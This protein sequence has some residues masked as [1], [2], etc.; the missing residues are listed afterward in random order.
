MHFDIVL[1]LHDSESWLPVCLAALSSARYDHARLH[2]IVVDNA[3]AEDPLPLFFEGDGLS[4]NFSTTQLERL[5]KNLGFGAGC[6]RGAALGSSEYI[7]FINVDTEVSPTLFAELESAISA[8]PPEVA[9]FE[10]RQLP[11]E[12][13]HHIDPVTLET[14]WASAAA[15]VV[16]RDA[17]EAVGGFDEHIFMYCED[18]DLSWRLRAAGYRIQYVPAAEVWHYSRIS[19][20]DE[21]GRDD[22]A[23]QVKLSEYTYGLL[24]NLLLRY[25]F[26]T[27]GDIRRGWA[28]YFRVLRRPVHYTHV[29][30]VLAK[31]FLKHL[32]Q[33]WP[34]LFWR[35]SH[36]REYTAGVARFEGGFSPDRGPFPL[37]K[38]TG[39]ALVSVVVRTCGRPDVLKRTLLS[40]HHQTYPNFEVVVVEDGPPI[41]RELVQQTLCNLPHRYYSTGENIGRSR[42]GNLGLS[43]TRGVWLNFLDDDDYF[44]PDHIELLAAQ[45]EAHPEASFVTA[46]SMAMEVNAESREPYVYTVQ[47]IYKMQYDRMDEFLLCQ[48]CLMPIQSILFKRELFEQYGGLNENIDGDEDWSMW[49]KYFAY[50]RRIHNDCVDIPRATSIFLVPADP[51]AARKR[52]EHYR[53][54]ED[55]ALDDDSIIFS[56]TPRRMRE[57]YEGLVGDL[58]HL[59]NEGKLEEYID[60]WA[61]RF[62]KK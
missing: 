36:R 11:I 26:G 29:R 50:G 9:A 17:F 46:A 43:K 45:L 56:A 18:V 33:Q 39:N 34:F 10:C 49:M 12:T 52:E 31:N 4:S 8:A 51:A 23:P 2:L 30:R 22:V 62:G 24:G 25:K 59:Q 44:Y 19:H 6:N 54:Y 13:G 41:S 60:Q 58:L 20:P 42:A 14:T 38:P 61:Q 7:L 28:L 5:P 37:K 32:G 55:Q 48:S 16:R 35:L 40:L 15:L 57:F 1:V 27:F 3:S 21:R 53:Q 47:D